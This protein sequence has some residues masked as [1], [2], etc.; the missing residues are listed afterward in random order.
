MFVAGV[1]VQKSKSHQPQLPTTEG[2]T[3]VLNQVLKLLQ[4]NVVATQAWVRSN[5]TPR[6]LL[7][8]AAA[9]LILA[10]P[11][12]PATFMQS[13]F[14]AGEWMDLC[15]ERGVRSARCAYGRLSASVHMFDGT[16]ISW[17]QCSAIGLPSRHKHGRVCVG[18]SSI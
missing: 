10:I 12:C 7:C 15:V 1:L 16:V 2:K 5:G 11:D 8:V 14:A 6:G 18:G 9:H 3:L 4:H 17:V 13:E